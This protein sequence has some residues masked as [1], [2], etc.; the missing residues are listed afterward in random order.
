M[1]YAVIIV[2]LLIACGKK[3]VVQPVVPEKIATTAPAPRAEGP[4]QPV[5]TPAPAPA[6][7]VQIPDMPVIHFDFDQFAIR[8]SEI[9]PLRMVARIMDDH[10]EITLQ[11]AGHCCEIGTDQY[12]MALGRH[13]AA[14]VA[15]FLHGMG[16]DPERVETVSY[17]ET[18]PVSDDLELNRR[19]EFEIK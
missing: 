3:P 12:N 16:V 4:A 13:R 17:G 10:P 5:V 15:R 9:Y 19:V 6:A 8:P 14:S 18:R 7:A 2:A 11:V 1:K